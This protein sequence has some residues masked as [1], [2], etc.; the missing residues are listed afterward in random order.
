MNCPYCSKEV[1]K[2]TGKEIYFGRFP[3]LDSK[4]FY[5]CKPCKAHVGCHPGTD[6]PL[7][8]LANAEL[9][10]WKQQA[11]A[12]FDPIWQDGWLKRSE[13][14]SL[15]AE[16]LDIPKEQCHIGMFDVDMCMKV[17]VEAVPKIRKWLDENSN[18]GLVEKPTSEPTP[19][20]RPFESLGFSLEIFTDGACSGNPGPGGF[21]ALVLKRGK[22]IQEMCA[23][24][25]H[26]TNNRM[27]MM[28][29][30]VGLEYALTIIDS[31]TERIL[32]TTDSKYVME[33]ITRWVQGWKRNGWQTKAKQPVKNQDLWMRLDDLQAKLNVTY[34]WVK[35][36]AGHKWNERADELARQGIKIRGEQTDTFLKQL[37]ESVGMLT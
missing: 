16:Q 23:G 19:L 15:L 21:G 11:H 22:V 3:E 14:Y 27:E 17:V 7:G 35:G 25:D 24:E 37:K 13:S 2:V 6:S 26:T 8:R 20:S 10:K 30:I 34:K 1:E 29:V 4:I 12:A 9:R 33:G 36:H 28:A 18:D 32:V 5:Q 31:H